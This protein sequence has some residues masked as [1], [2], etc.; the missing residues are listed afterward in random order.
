MADKLVDPFDAPVPG[1]ASLEK[2]TTGTASGLVDPFDEGGP[3]RFEA[4][5]SRAPLKE[6]QGRAMGREV[7]VE[8]GVGGFGLSF[9]QGLLIDE[10]TKLKLAAAELFPDDPKAVERFGFVNGRVA[11]ENDQGQLQYASGRAA[12]FFGNL[13]ANAPEIAGG[14]VGSFAASP[15][16]GTTAGVTA[17]R[18]LK[19][20]AAGLLLDEPQTVEGNLKDIGKTAAIELGT[21]GAAKGAI[22]L[23]NRGRSINLTPQ[24]LAAAQATQSRIKQNTG[25]DTDLALASGD[26]R[27]LGVRNYLA[28][29]PNAGADILQAADEQSA[30]Q[31]GKAAEAVLDKVSKGAPADTLGRQGVNAAKEAIRSARRSVSD[32]VRPLYD[33]AY[34]SQP[35]VDDPDV[36]KY[37]DLPHFGAAFKVGQR[38][39][40]LEGRE[41]PPGQYSLESL[42][43]TKRG[44]DDVIE[45]LQSSGKRQEARAL[46]QRKNEFVAQLDGLSNDAYRDARQAYAQAIKAEVEP[47]EKGIVGVVANIKDNKTA[48]IAAKLFRDQN[49]TP[50]EIARARSALEKQDPE[51]WNSLVRQFLSN[52]LNAARKVT[53]AGSEVNVP[54]KFHQRIWGDPEGRKRMGAA[55]GTDASKALEGLMETAETLGKAPVRGSNTQPNQ[56]IA[57]TLEGP[58]GWWARVLLRP[59]ES[60]VDAAQQKAVDQNAV[61]LVEA[62]TNPAKVRQLKIATKISDPA[63]RVTF[64]TSV[65][66]AETAGPAAQYVSGQ[67]ES[68]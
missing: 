60:F 38:I 13:A 5:A 21:A 1:R 8:P 55:L 54:G 57:K 50:G 51:A 26:R 46:T 30:E 65:L 27:L 37:L 12:E 44:L 10:P 59:R 68:E 52:E 22:A 45:K 61:K 11:F 28:Q 14:I 33:K 29:Q 23:A 6:T 41:L 19:R 43:Y 40:K 3:T 67:S 47:L 49:V 34:A 42:D 66:G 63:Q 35:V 2:E 25:V 58:A 39:A 56:A 32:K 20:A 18:G 4:A 31:F 16:V 48:T 64:I 9:K 24:D 7:S 53:Q 17:G 15:V 62:L 36:I